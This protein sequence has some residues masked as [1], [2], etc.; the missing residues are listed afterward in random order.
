MLPTNVVIEV[1]L[2]LEEAAAQVTTERRCVAGI[3]CGGTLVVCVAVRVA[4]SNIAVGAV[5]DLADTRR[6]SLGLSRSPRSQSE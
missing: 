2:A 6:T 5:D 1:A 4:G 3:A